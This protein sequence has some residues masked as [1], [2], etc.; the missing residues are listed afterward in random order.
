M[1]RN[2]CYIT[3]IRNVCVQYIAPYI[4]TSEKVE[5]DE[6]IKNIVW[7]EITESGLTNVQSLH[8]IMSRNLRTHTHVQ[9]YSVYVNSYANPILWT[10]QNKPDRI[11]KPDI[12]IPFDKY[13]FLP[14]YETTYTYPWVAH[15]CI[16]TIHGSNILFLFHFKL[17][18]GLCLMEK[19][20]P[21]DV[22]PIQCNGCKVW[23]DRRIIDT[24]AIKYLEI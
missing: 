11:S 7:N 1:T 18:I 9:I 19:P 14:A 2:A 21:I 6:E 4:Q 22:H 10:D 17:H 16:Y 15:T 8:C 24:L 20:K 13:E 23:K 3:R 5:I 12:S